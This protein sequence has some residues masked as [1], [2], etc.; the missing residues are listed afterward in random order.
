MKASQNGG[1]FLSL[2]ESDPE[3]RKHLSAAE[4][5]DHFNLDHHF[6]H[7]DTI[8]KRVFGRAS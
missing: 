1:E 8:F 2:L 3:L 5:A 6:K 4:L 7:V